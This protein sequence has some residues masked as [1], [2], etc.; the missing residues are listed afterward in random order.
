[1]ARR[2]GDW[3]RRALAPDGQ[4][5]LQARAHFHAPWPAGPIAAQPY[6]VFDLES[7][8][9]KPSR[10]DVLLSIGAVRLQD[11]APVAE[12]QTLVEPGRAIPPE[13]TRY[14]GLT[15][16]MLAG[17]PRA[18]E[19]IACFRDFAEGAV[20]VAHSAAFDRSLL[21]MEEHRG[22]PA[23]PNPFLCSLLVSRWLDPQ[24]GDHSLDGL[25]GR[26]GI[27]ITGRHEALGDARAT[28]ELW[29]RLLARAG[30][31]GVADLADLARRSRMESQMAESAAHF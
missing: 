20:L 14:H 10:G 6:V 16:E 13:S 18:P 21:Y 4:A 17:A 26:E 12:F 22:A 1:M 3:L 8:G 27:V 2:I 11:A 29:V 23:L 7:T 24:E 5:F 31:R 25:C 28:A 19:A 30:A 15:R 9:L